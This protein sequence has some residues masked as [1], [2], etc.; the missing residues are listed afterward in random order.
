[1]TK[2]KF[3]KETNNYVKTD[4]TT[5]STV[6]PVTT[7]NAVYYTSTKTIYD[8][9]NSTYDTSNTD[10]TENGIF[11]WLV[12]L[13]NQFPSYVTLKSYNELYSKYLTLQTSMTNVLNTSI[14]T[15]SMIKQVSNSFANQITAIK[16]SIYSPE[17]DSVPTKGSVKL[18][19]SGAIYSYFSKLINKNMFD[20][21]Q[22]T[23]LSKYDA[24]NGEIVM[25]IGT[26]TETY[27][28]GSL[29][30][31]TVTYTKD[32]DNPC[33]KVKVITWTLL[34]SLIETG[35]ID[36]SNYYTKAEVDK[37][38]NDIIIPDNIYYAGAN[39]TISDTN[40]ISAIIPD[41]DLSNYYNKAEVDDLIAS[42]SSKTNVYTA[43]DNITIENNI[44]SATIPD[45]TGYTTTDYVNNKIEEVSKD[46]IKYQAGYGISINDDTISTILTIDDILSD[47]SSNAISNKAV[48]VA[49]SKKATASDYSIVAKS[50]SYNDL[51]D[52]PTINSYELVA[53]T[54]NI[55][56]DKTEDT[57][58]DTITYT[59]NVDK[60]SV[61]NKDVTLEYD[62]KSIIATIDNTNITLS[63]PEQ[64]TINVDNYNPIL[65]WGAKTAIGAINGNTLSVIMPE[66]PTTEIDVINNDVDLEFGKESTIANI[67]GTDITVTMPEMESINTLFFSVD[68]W[69][70]FINLYNKYNSKTGTISKTTSIEIS[71]T[72]EIVTQPSDVNYELNLSNFKIHGHYNK[73][74]LQE[75]CKL[76]GNFAYFES[77]WFCDNIGYTTIFQLSGIDSKSA[78]FIFENCRFYNFFTQ[79][80]H[81]FELDA[82]NNK[83][84]HLFIDRCKFNND[85]ASTSN[86]AILFNKIATSQYGS[87]SVN[88]INLLNTNKSYE[89]NKIAVTGFSASSSTNSNL[90]SND[91]FV[92]DNSVV[93]DTTY[94]YP[95]HNRNISTGETNS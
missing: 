33:K 26:T 90:S 93:Y 94:P 29:Y 38:L 32:E 4:I 43:G 57:E 55:T 75:T 49:L 10:P 6:Y 86:C 53:G 89:C 3:L 62:T 25:Y 69:D 92:F 22:T 88:I 61:E 80:F 50:G 54:D 24:V 44:I 77:V 35:D 14:E 41:I 87:I 82:S 48:T 73:W 79:V 16:N 81:L 23:D 1:M 21:E 42:L 66:K 68:S 74:H 28:F 47:D 84:I 30:Q 95:S 13:T 78:D 59:L 60:S 46:I 85:T 8:I 34:G 72:G 7:S 52:K 70:S 20:F 2:I 91:S 67:A 58:N 40:V 18:L 45:L 5:G 71:L 11:Q 19:N 51:I 65:V 15:Q 83:G 9:L 56:I 31:A 39:I 63:M 27:T 64:L 12:Y 37:K 17:F 76:V 36:L